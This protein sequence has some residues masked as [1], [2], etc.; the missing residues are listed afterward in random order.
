M[1]GDDE[2]V[3]EDAILRDAL[4]LGRPRRAALL[5]VEQLLLSAESTK[6]ATEHT[7]LND[8]EDLVAYCGMDPATGDDPGGEYMGVHSDLNAGETGSERNSLTKEGASEMCE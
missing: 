6:V 1:L 7:G 3:V 8:V 2:E 4:D 5:P